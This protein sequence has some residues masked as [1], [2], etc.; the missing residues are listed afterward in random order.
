MPAANSITGLNSGIDYTKII[1]AT[2]EFERNNA[3][4]LELEQ[5]QK[6]SIISAYQALQAKFLALSVE[7]KKLA[8]PSSFE[9]GSVNVSDETVLSAS[10]EGRLSSGSYN[11]Q[12][13]SLA[14]N[15]Q[16]ASQGFSDSAVSSFG[17]G[18]ISIKVGDGSAQIVTIDSGNNSLVGIKQAINDAKLGV[19]ASIINDGSD[20]NSYRLILT[21][22]NTGAANTIPL[23]R[24]SPAGTILISPIHHLMLPKP[25]R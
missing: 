4:L 14:R 11:V 22:D 25:S 13:L 3:V 7:L 21:G 1:D 10:S 2:I 20:T 24:T 5:A 8:K 15:H 19:R 6:Q 18:N 12:V 9:K 16:L 23:R 17:T